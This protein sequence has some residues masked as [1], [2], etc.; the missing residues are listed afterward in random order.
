M[1]EK[2]KITVT[3]G[4]SRAKNSIGKDTR[5]QDLKCKTREKDSSERKREQLETSMSE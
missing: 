1:M 3:W 2:V 5:N 4:E